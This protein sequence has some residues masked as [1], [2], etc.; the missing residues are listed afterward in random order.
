MFIDSSL[1]EIIESTVT[2]KKQG[3]RKRST[4]HVIVN[5]IPFN[6]II[7]IINKVVPRGTATDSSKVIR[8][9][10][11]NSKRIWETKIQGLYY[12]VMPAEIYFNRFGLEQ[13]SRNER[14]KVFLIFPIVDG[15]IPIKKILPD[16]LLKDSL[17]K[18]IREDT[19][20]CPIVVAVP[21]T[22]KFKSL[23]EDDAYFESFACSVLNNNLL[24][25]ACFAEKFIGLGATQYEDPIYK[26][27][28]I[29][30]E[31]LCRRRELF[32]FLSDDASYHAALSKLRLTV[33]E[34]MTLYTSKEALLRDLLQLKVWLHRMKID[35][36]NF[37]QF[38]W[39]NI[40][41]LGA[42]ANNLPEV[43][44]I[45]YHLMNRRCTNL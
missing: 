5:N 26:T 37:C 19:S 32:T 36:F 22:S 44:S 7:P 43:D 4:G 40:Q 34:A 29:L 10:Y 35:F 1:V 13:H 27:N 24:K 17:I 41:L 11:S 30:S 33:E 31:M 45:T 16:K 21:F 23:L 6:T 12:R 8:N 9:F 28:N 42:A 20:N 25:I 3:P 39:V 15:P 38:D 2:G 14:K 18:E